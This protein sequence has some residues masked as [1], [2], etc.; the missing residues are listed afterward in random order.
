MSGIVAHRTDSFRPRRAAKSPPRA[1]G[2]RAAACRSS[3]DEWVGEN[4]DVRLDSS[5]MPQADMIADVARMVEAV[6][7]GR[8]G[9]QELA[10]HI[11]KVD[12]QGRYYRLAAESI[13]LLEP[14]QAGVSTLTPRGVAYR[15]ARDPQERRSVLVDGVMSN[16]V[17][18]GLLNHISDAGV[19]GR[20]RSELVGWL[21]DNTTMTGSTPSRRVNTATRWLEDLGLVTAT[22]GRYRVVADRYPTSALAPDVLDPRQSVTAVAPALLPFGEQ[23]PQPRSLEPN[24]ISYLIDR[25]ALER[26]SQEH[27]ELVH[28]VAA[29]ARAA[30]HNCSRNVFVD[31]FVSAPHARYLCEMK[32]NNAQNTVSQVRKAVSQLYEYA[33]QQD[34]EDAVL[35][36]VLQQ[37]PPPRSSWLVGYLV[38][39]RGILPVWSDGAGGFTGPPASTDALP[40][41]AA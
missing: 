16:P 39:A 38:D 7:V 15:D 21:A 22:A 34:L 12:R 5:L 31:L 36:L 25:A 20:T 19:P 35:V 9:D 41:L 4:L 30:G 24:V 37:P 18:R 6:A 1:I 13:G 3:S 10:D 2:S 28:A 11:G 14:V 27:E 32:T 26:A 29:R 17:L 8:N 40:W 33:Y 23:A